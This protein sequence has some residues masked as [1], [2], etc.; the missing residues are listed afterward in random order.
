MFPFPGFL[1]W[2]AL[3]THVDLED[4][5][6]TITVHAPEGEDARHGK[7]IRCFINNPLVVGM[8]NIKVPEVSK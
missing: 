1:S 8:E 7:Y 2:D 5:L 3:Q 4:E 6:N